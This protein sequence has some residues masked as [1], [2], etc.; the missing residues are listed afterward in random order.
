MDGSRPCRLGDGCSCPCP[1]PCPHDAP[2]SPGR[3]HGG[4]SP[5]PV[6]LAMPGV[7]TVPGPAVSGD[8]VVAPVTAA[9]SGPSPTTTRPP[10]EARAHLPLP[11]PRLPAA[12]AS[13]PPRGCLAVAP[14][15]VPSP[16]RRPGVPSPSR[17]PSEVPSTALRA[18]EFLVPA[19]LPTHR[20]RQGTQG[21]PQVRAP[22][23]GALDDRTRAPR[24]AT[25]TSVH[26]SAAPHAPARGTRSDT[27]SASG[28]RRSEGSERAT[29]KVRPAPRSPERST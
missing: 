2:P 9:D 13:P 14:L 22:P 16:S 8:P 10:P 17:L 4:R 24:R 15:R 19:P 23:D 26:V 11:R 29:G 25:V 1:C 21:R 5:R 18:T 12:R 3:T 20:V 6:G 27:A 7:T 28:P